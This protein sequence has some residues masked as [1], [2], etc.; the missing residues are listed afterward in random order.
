[1][2]GYGRVD[3]ASH[4]FGNRPR[5]KF[6]I[7]RRIIL[8]NPEARAA[9]RAR[10]DLAVVDR[11]TSRQSVRP[12]EQSE[13]DLVPCPAESAV[14]HHRSAVV[15]SAVGIVARLGRWGLNC[16]STTRAVDRRP[17]QGR[18]FESSVSS[19]AEIG[20]GRRTAIHGPTLPKSTWQTSGRRQCGHSGLATRSR[21]GCQHPYGCLYCHRFA[22]DRCHDSSPI[23]KA[24]RNAG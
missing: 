12:G 21:Y 3:R 4:P 1:M 22:S 24:L 9:V 14:V 15:S 7:S 10:L 20:H 17:S 16:W 6:G 8:G 19:P 11:T 2:G 18:T 5:S 13:L 23:S